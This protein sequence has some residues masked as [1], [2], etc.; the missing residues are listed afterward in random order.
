MTRSGD[1]PSSAPSSS[2]VRAKATAAPARRAVSRI[3]ATKKRS[4]TTATALIVLLRIAEPVPAPLGQVGQGGEVLH[5][6]HVDEAVEI[7]RLV[8]HDAGDELPGDHAELFPRPIKGLEAHRRV[9]R[10]HAPHVRDGQ[11]PFPA[12]FHLH[13]EWG[14]HR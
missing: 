5:A 4:L 11:T 8:L 7:V 2:G 12:V 14:H 1:S 13:G 9:A 10:Y 6:V 3:R